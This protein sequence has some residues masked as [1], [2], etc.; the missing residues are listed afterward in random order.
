MALSNGDRLTLAQTADG[1]TVATGPVKNP[2]KKGD[3]CILV[4]TADGVTVPALIVPMTK[5]GQRGLLAQTAD[6][7]AVPVKF[8]IQ[9]SCFS[10]QDTLYVTMPS[11]LSGDFSSFAGNTYECTR[12]TDTCVW[13]KEGT[14]WG[15]AIRW[16]DDDKRWEINIDPDTFGI[17]CVIIWAG[18]YDPTDPIVDYTKLACDDDG[19]D[20]TTSCENSS[21]NPTVSY[22]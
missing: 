6:G 8:K 12:V 19:C 14:D 13:N 21:G 3:R 5:S 10:V 1:A 15:I 9:G 16:R 11:G 20:D 4:E 17:R 2:T 22:T 7:V 18:G